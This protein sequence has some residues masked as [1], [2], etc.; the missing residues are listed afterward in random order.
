MKTI[1][2]IKLTIIIILALTVLS[3]CGGSSTSSGIAVASCSGAIS[4]WTTVSG[5]DVVSATTSSQIKFDHD[6][7]GNKKVCV[8]SGS[9]TVL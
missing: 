6:S 7:G 4:T 8:V 9:A 2:K 3:G 1:S 5:G